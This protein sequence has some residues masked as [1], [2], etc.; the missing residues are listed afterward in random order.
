MKVKN[1]I[2]AKE[3]R[4]SSFWSRWAC[5]TQFSSVVASCLQKVTTT[6]LVFRANFP[7]ALRRRPKVDRSLTTVVR[8]LLFSKNC[9]NFAWRDAILFH[10]ISFLSVAWVMQVIMYS[11]SD[12]VLSVFSESWQER[13]EASSWNTMKKIKT[14][15]VNF[16]FYNVSKQQRRTKLLKVLSVCS[17]LNPRW[18]VHLQKNLHR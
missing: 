9:V 6:S 12:V 10:N 15:R 5:A 14:Y 1:R 16:S 13:R 11:V 4:G 7:R 8:S 2:G 3:R 18:T 17:V